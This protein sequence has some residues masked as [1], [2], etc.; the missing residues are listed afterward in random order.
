[1]T[2]ADKPWLKHYHEGVPTHVDI[3]EISI[4]EML[5]RT[6]AKI[7]DNNAI[8]FMGRKIPYRELKDNVDRLATALVELGI[9]RGDVVAIHLPN[10][11]QFIIAYYAALKAGARVTCVSALLTPPEVKFQL[12]DSGAKAIV[13]MDGAPLQVVNSIRSETKLQHVIVTALMDYLP[14]KPRRPAEKEGTKQFLNLITDHQPNPPKFKIDPK[15]EVAVLQYTGGTTGIPKGAMLTHRNLVANA[16][17]AIS[18]ISWF[19]EFGKETGVVNLPLF[20][21]YAMTACMNAPVAF[22]WCMALNPDPRDLPSLLSIIR[23]TKPSFFPGVPTVYMRLLQVKG[24]EKYYDDLKSIKICLSGA[25]PMP[26]EVMK[27]FEQTTGGTVLEA[28]GLTET[29]P[30][31]HISPS[32]EGRKIGSIGP[33]IADTDCR[34][35]DIETGTKLMPVGEAGELAIKGPQVMKGYWNKPEETRNQLRKEIAGDLGPWLL[36]GDIA[37]MDQDG[38]FYIV[39]RKKDM[40]DVSGF[41]VY[42]REV[43]DVLF[44]HPSVAMAAAIGVPDPKTPGSERV[45]AFVVVKPGIAE[46]DETKRSII[47]FA[48]TKLAPYK[49]P[50]E[51]EFRKELPTTLVGK[52]LKR[53]I[54]EEEK[55]KA[56]EP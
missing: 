38:F 40:I 44:E 49:V 55:Q 46:D 30:A 29:C 36:T 20:H 22:G 26:P 7:P 17:Q 10:L 25:A 16:T 56:G 54:R 43:D 53:H 27:Q 52:V 34:I 23:S 2:Y 31:T 50:R 12:N 4:P 39:D 35:V 8:W 21:I 48:K 32:K 13:T 9:K 6:A 28:Y 3:P 19:Y 42:P 24:V 18:W 47:E 37:K 15:E 41:K 33:P 45:K 11:P 14:G 5:D 51:I 1:M